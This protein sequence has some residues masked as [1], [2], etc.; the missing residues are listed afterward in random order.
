MV[1]PRIYAVFEGRSW[2]EKSGG[3]IGFFSK[4]KAIICHYLQQP[5][6]AS[7]HFSPAGL[8]LYFEKLSR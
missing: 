5:V 2:F 3:N 8:R 1:A 4:A 6:L 7:S